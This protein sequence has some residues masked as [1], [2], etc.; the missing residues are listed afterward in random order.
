MVRAA[1]I[2]SLALAPLANAQ[3]ALGSRLYQHFLSKPAAKKIE[4]P[5]SRTK[6]GTSFNY[7]MRVMDVLMDHPGQLATLKDHGQ[8]FILG[9][10][11]DHNP[12]LLVVGPEQQPQIFGDPTIVQWTRD[13]LFRKRS[14]AL[15]DFAPQGDP[16]LFM[17]KSYP[18]WNGITETAL[19]QARRRTFVRVQRN[20]VFGQFS[21]VTKLVAALSHEELGRT[22]A[23]SEIYMCSP[24]AL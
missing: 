8:L 12:C 10:E 20:G 24:N 4:I 19:Q 17:N 6:D 14:L 7:R 11:L 2:F 13:Y 3:D 5:F 22:K 9:E 1:F 18:G 15:R 16:W 23:V 21:Y